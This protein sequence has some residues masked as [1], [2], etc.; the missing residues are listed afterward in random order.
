MEEVSAYQPS[1]DPLSLKIPTLARKLHFCF[2]QFSESFRNV[3][4]IHK[5]PSSSS[6]SSARENSR[7][8]SP[9]ALAVDDLATERSNRA[10]LELASVR[11]KRLEDGPEDSKKT[12]KT[13]EEVMQSFLA[14]GASMFIHFS[15]HLQ[16]L[17]L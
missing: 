9:R 15:H 11:S 8:V 5:N 10:R 13:S 7:F 1:P 14:K 16:N 4:A 17:N 2:Q 12:P 6:P 3:A